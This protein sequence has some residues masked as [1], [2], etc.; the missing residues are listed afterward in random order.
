M[1]SLCLR[2]F[3]SGFPASSHNPENMR[4]RW[5]ENSKL[6]GGVYVSANG[7]LAVFVSICDEPAT[8]KNGWVSFNYLSGSS[9][10]LNGQWRPLVAGRLT[11]KKQAKMRQG[12]RQRG[13]NSLLNL[14]MFFFSELFVI[15]GLF[16]NPLRKRRGRNKTI[17]NNKIH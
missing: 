1:Y 10:S 5:I 3:S 16:Y 7:W 15:S 13:L 4:V 9:I 17:N 14:F 2:G 8:S 11:G 12:V 6:S